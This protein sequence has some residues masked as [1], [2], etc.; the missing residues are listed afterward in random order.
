MILETRA[1]GCGGGGSG[2]DEVIT[3]ADCDDDVTL[4]RQ[5]R[6]W[7]GDWFKDLGK[8]IVKSIPKMSLRCTW[9]CTK[10]HLRQR[11]TKPAGCCCN[12]FAWE[13]GC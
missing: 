13:K 7:F 11:S 6:G 3:R 1:Q 10:Y 2:E 8:K 4:M 5:R 9:E 12:R